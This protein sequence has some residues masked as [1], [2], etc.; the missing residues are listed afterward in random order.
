MS[1]RDRHNYWKTV[2]Q[3]LSPM[4]ARKPLGQITNTAQKSQVTP[5]KSP[6]PLKSPVK[7]VVPIPAKPFANYQLQKIT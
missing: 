5:S 3:S 4:T 2:R 7:F 6:L 1:Y